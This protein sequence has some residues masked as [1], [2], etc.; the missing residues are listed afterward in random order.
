[1]LQMP[2][3]ILT[4]GKKNN[5]KRLADLPNP[6]A[7]LGQINGLSFQNKFSSEGRR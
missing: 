1:M 6:Y 4:E 7:Y 2:L 3:F 5:I